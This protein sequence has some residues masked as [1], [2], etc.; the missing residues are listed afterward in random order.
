MCGGVKPS[1]MLADFDFVGYGYGPKKC[2]SNKKSAFKSPIHELKAVLMIRSRQKS[3]S[4]GIYLEAPFLL[5]NQQ[6]ED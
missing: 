4:I 3:L 6:A 1:K 2:D 5:I